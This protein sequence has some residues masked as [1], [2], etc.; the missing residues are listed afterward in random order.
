MLPVASLESEINSDINDAAV[1]GNE[2]R[3]LC[4]H[5]EKNSL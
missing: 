2:K 4:V 1:E 5:F 3:K